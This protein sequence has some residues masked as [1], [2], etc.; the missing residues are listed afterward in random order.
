MKVLIE[1]YL[2]NR[3][4]SFPLQPLKPKHHYLSHYPDLTIHFGP[5]IRLWTLRFESKHTYFKQCA[6][7]LHN[8]KNLCSTLAEGHQLLQ[9][10]LGAGYIFPPC[11]SVE[12][13]TDFYVQDF[14]VKIQESVAPFSFQPSN[15]FVAH[16]ASVKGTVYKKNMCVVLEKND[17][18]LVFGRIKLILID[19]RTVVYFVAEKFQSVF[20]VD[21]GIY[22]LTDST[23]YPLNRMVEKLVQQGVETEEDLYVTEEDIGEFM[24]PIQCRKLLYTVPISAPTMQMPTSI[25]LDQ[26]SSLASSS[27]SSAPASPSPSR[28][29][30]PDLFKVNWEKMPLSLRAAI[31][32]GK[33]PSPADRRQMICILVDDIRKIEVEPMCLI[34]ASDIT[35]QCPQSFMDTMDN[36]TST[37]G[38]G[39]ESL[40]SQIKTR[41]E[42]LNRNNTLARRRASKRSS[43]RTQR[44]PADSYGC[45]QWQPDLPPEET[46]E[47]EQNKRQKLMEIFSRDGS[48]GMEK[49][50]VLN[51][52]ESTHYLQRQM[53]NADPAPLLED[54]KQQWPYLFFPR[55]MC[56]DF[57]MLTGISVIRK[58]ESFLEAHGRNIMEFFKQNP[59][60]DDVKTRP[61]Q[62]ITA[63]RWM[64]SIDHEVLCEGSSFV[65]GLAVLFATYYNFNLHYQ[66]DAACTLEFIQRYD[67]FRTY[68]ISLISRTF[69]W[70]FFN[71]C[72]F[73]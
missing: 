41:I 3:S 52:M 62:Y 70:V 48:S 18:G 5:L 1:E 31:Q 20:L 34:I 64:R 66:H 21:Q 42:H 60:S 73:L 17:E 57:E 22:G 12:R 72:G 47:S 8:F 71:L 46:I 30:W 68:W 35:R 2:Q 58:I 23:S 51:L 39:Y 25:P 15:T 16:E 26:T 59:T 40:L 11:L 55:S 50:E 24:K 65:L 43:E 10:Y 37:V 13:G 36:G 63:R 6:R 9:A 28:A 27:M 61:A 33:R 38:A 67:L 45:T 7:K 4:E 14:N 53:I 32:N 19:S 49:A 44:G 29:N 56:T 54:L 69:S